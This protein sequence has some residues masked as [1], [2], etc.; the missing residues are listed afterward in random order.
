MALLII[1][2]FVVAAAVVFLTINIMTPVL[3]DMWFNQLQDQ[4]DTESAAIGD[5]AFFMFQIMGYLVPGI[6]IMSGFA[7]A[8]RKSVRDQAFN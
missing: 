8:H 5:R 4:N 2:P 6:I 7:A 1:I 3:Y